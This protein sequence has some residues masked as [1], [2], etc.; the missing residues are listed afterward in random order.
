M[1]KGFPELACA[2]LMLATAGKA[3][4]AQPPFPDLAYAGTP[5]AIALVPPDVSGFGV[6]AVTAVALPDGRLWLVGSAVNDGAGGG[7]RLPRPAFAMLTASGAPDASFGPNHDGLTIFDQPNSSAVDAVRESGTRLVYVGSAS[8]PIAMIGR[9]TDAGAP[10]TSFDGDGQRFIGGNAFLAGATEAIF[11]G[12]ALQPDGKILAV[13]AAAALVNGT[14]NICTAVMRFNAEDGSSDASFGTAGHVCIAPENGTA[15]PLSEGAKIA[16][17]ADGRILIAGFSVHTGSSSTDF[18]VA[19]LMPNGDPDATFGPAHD[20]WAFVAFDEGGTLTDMANTIAL[21]AQGRIIVA[22]FVDSSTGARTGVAR[23][24][25]DGQP[26]PTFGTQGRV[27]L[28][29]VAGAQNL[30]ALPNGEIFTGGSSTTPG[31]FRGVAAMLRSDGT[32]DPRFGEGGIFEQ[33]D[34]VNPPDYFSSGPRVLAGDYIYWIGGTTDTH[35]AMAVARA[36]LPMFFDGFEA[37]PAD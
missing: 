11:Q 24:L 22:G 20:G 3:L 12:V 17:L 36:V 18:S 33:S 29:T 16:L 15:G 28:D 2:G 5:D 7:E 25:A 13:G 34:A 31:D 27:E 1:R 6:S 30:V 21:D 32:L 26:D 4:A 19:R 35:G 37:P 9:I 14:P 8:G 23:L 10:D